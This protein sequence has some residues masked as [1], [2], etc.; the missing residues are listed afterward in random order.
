MTSAELITAQAT[1]RRAFADLATFRR[2]GIRRSTDRVLRKVRPVE[3]V[4]GVGI[5]HDARQRA[6][7][8]RAVDHLVAGG[9]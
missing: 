8:A 9:R 4:I 2:G 1:P 5:D 6:A 3:I 7:A